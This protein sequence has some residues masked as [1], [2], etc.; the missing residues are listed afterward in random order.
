MA[1]SRLAS[2]RRYRVASSV[3]QG[4]ARGSQDR[5]GI[6]RRG[7]NAQSA[8]TERV[9]G[10]TTNTSPVPSESPVTLI[11]SPVRAS[12]CPSPSRSSMRSP[13]MRPTYSLGQIVMSGGPCPRRARPHSGCGTSTEPVVGESQAGGPTCNG[14]GAAVRRA[15]GSRGTSASL[16][17]FQRRASPA[18]TT[19]TRIASAAAIAARLPRLI[20]SGYASPGPASDLS[21]Q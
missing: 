6:G 7:E 3:L 5:G 2:R 19:S 14:P 8:M 12:S 20:S 4:D 21:H 18:P 16:S 11:R 1:P 10:Q 17:A 15:T 13:T 9:P